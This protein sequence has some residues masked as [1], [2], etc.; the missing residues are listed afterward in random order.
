MK[1]KLT[2]RIPLIM[3]I[4]SICVIFIFRGIPL[5]TVVVE[6]FSDNSSTSDWFVNYK[7]T[8][9]D[10]VF[11]GSLLN[12]LLV[13][14]YIPILL[15]LSFIVSLAIEDGVKFANLYK[16]IIV[17]PQI[18]S[19]IT[20]ASIF[21]CLFGYN[22]P[23]NAIVEMLGI[24]ALYWLGEKTTAIFVIILCVV[25]SSFGWQTLIFSSA[26]STIDPNIKMLIKLDGV[27][28]IQRF[29]I[30]LQQIKSTVYYSLILNII[31]GF[32]GNFS[33]IYTLTHGGPGYS[34]TTI[35][36]LIY[37]RSFKYGSDLSNAYTIASLLLL[38]V[39]ILVT[40]LYLILKRRSAD[41][42][43]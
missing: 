16:T 3:L 22:G 17:F 9:S 34:T 10:E 33:I 13:L 11:W 35:D 27:N 1:N 21:G 37:L 26:L 32:A 12:S 4:I 2:S 31:Y 30:Y 5:L 39:L 6:S 18:V 23:I 7:N 15:V 38:L 20:I 28:F 29:Y 14:M 41:E 43:T 36:Y 8:L 40:V 24:P 42:T 19:T 25:Y